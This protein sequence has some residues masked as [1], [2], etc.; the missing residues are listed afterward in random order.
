MKHESTS[1]SPPKALSH[2]LAM[3]IIRKRHEPNLGQS[4]D[5]G[6]FL[7]ELLARPLPLGSGAADSVEA[8]LQRP[9][10]ELSGVENRPVGR[11]LTDPQT[12]AA[13]LKAIKEYAKRRAASRA[14]EHDSYLTVYYA[15]MA[16][17]LVFQGQR[18]TRL[19]RERLNEG[20]DWLIAMP[21]VPA[22]LKEL[23]RKARAVDGSTASP[24]RS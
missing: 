3:G 24:P 7:A 15:A 23:F 21:W 1:G 6:A 10:P 14:S 22:E 17:A 19:S 5:Q 18:V 16:A 8:V 11:L 13:A 9:C 12:N 20:L 4:P 2:L